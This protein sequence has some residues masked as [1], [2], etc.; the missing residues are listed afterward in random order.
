[1]RCSACRQTPSS[2]GAGTGA[3]RQLLAAAFIRALASAQRA[4]YRS[5]APCE[6]RL[7]GRLALRATLYGLCDGQWSPTT[8]GW[9]GCVTRTASGMRLRV[10]LSHSCGMR[11]HGDLPHPGNPYALRGIE[12]RTR[13]ALLKWIRPSSRN[14]VMSVESPCASSKSAAVAVALYIRPRCE[15]VDRAAPRAA[16]A[17]RGACGASG[18]RGLG[19]HCVVVCA[20]A[21]N[22]VRSAWR[23]YR[24]HTTIDGFFYLLSESV[25]ESR[26]GY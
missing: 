22:K 17:A 18:E 15:A 2:P 3:P 24:F 5:I 10:A 21:V 9:R 14:P 6:R 20:F 11:P 26:G 25:Y 16:G 1:L 23:S 13:D 12:C 19:A 8:T 7:A 4:A